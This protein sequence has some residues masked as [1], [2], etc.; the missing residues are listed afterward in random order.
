[1]TAAS[2]N[3]VTSQGYQTSGQVTNLINTNQNVIDAKKHTQV[4]IS[5][6]NVNYTA[7]GNAAAASLTATLYIDGVATTSNVTY[8]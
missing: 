2:Q 8:Q 3:Y 7:T 6:A 5:A 4:I 1:M